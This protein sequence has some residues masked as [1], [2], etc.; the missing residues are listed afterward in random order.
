MKLDFGVKAACV[1]ALVLS[2]TV[3]S[4]CPCSNTLKV[5]NDT[6]NPITEVYVRHQLQSD[7]GDNLISSSILPGETENV[8]QLVPG[9]YDVKVVYLI[10]GDSTK[11][12]CIFCSESVT[13]DATD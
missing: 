8:K 11:E 1:A 7:F 10:G 5:H 4:G 12:V 2:G 3:L 13:V 9:C 6:L